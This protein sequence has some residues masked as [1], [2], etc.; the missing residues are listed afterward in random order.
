MD[1]LLN[2]LLL[3]LSIRVYYYVHETWHAQ[4]LKAHCHEFSCVVDDAKDCKHGTQCLH[5]LQVRARQTAVLDGLPEGLQS[6]IVTVCLGGK[7]GREVRVT[8]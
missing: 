6:D 7:G 5:Y 3:N 8:D 1:F 2:T 4:F